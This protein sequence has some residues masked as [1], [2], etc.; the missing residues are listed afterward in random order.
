VLEV[1]D[2]DAV[3]HVEVEL[4]L[5]E[6]D[7][8]ADAKSEQAVRLA[9]AEAGGEPLTTDASGWRVRLTTSPHRLDRAIETLRGYGLRRLVRAGSVAMTTPNS[10]SNGANPS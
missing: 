9:I 6:L 2:L 7:A 1:E 3:P 4:A 10:H 8:P 5:V